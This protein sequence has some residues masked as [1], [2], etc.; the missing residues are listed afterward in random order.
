MDNVVSIVTNKLKARLIKENI[1]INDSKVTDLVVSV[2]EIVETCDYLSGKEKETCALY[3]IKKI[4]DLEC[5]KYSDEFILSLI[6]TIIKASKN[7]FKINSI[8]K[9]KCYNFKC[10]FA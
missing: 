4:I 5:M 10:C 6:N 1:Q 9:S 3:T 2:I 8:K 7:E